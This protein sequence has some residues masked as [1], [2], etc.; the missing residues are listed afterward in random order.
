MTH[1]RSQIAET[2]KHT[3]ILPAIVIVSRVS[4]YICSF[5]PAV[6]TMCNA[7]RHNLERQRH[8]PNP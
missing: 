2:Q 1:I 6:V 5:G 8:K 4:G 7:R 3:E